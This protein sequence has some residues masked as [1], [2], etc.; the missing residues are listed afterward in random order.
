MVAAGIATAV[1]FE[2][3]EASQEED[4]PQLVVDAPRVGERAAELESFRI[5]Y[6]VVEFENEPRTEEHS[7]L[8]PYHGKVISERDGA[9]LT[10]S[11]SNE[12]GAFT[13]VTGTQQGWQLIDEGRKTSF[14]DMYADVALAW[15]LDK[16]MAEERGTETV[17]GRECTVFRTGAP[18]GAPVTAATDDEH[19]D[20]CVDEAGLILREDWHIDG[21]EVRRME[22]VEVDLDADLDP[23]DFEPDVRLP[24]LPTEA[25]GVTRVRKMTAVDRRELD[26]EVRSPEGYSF[27][28]A[29]VRERSADQGSFLSYVERFQDGHVLLDVEHGAH[30]PGYEPQGEVVDIGGGAKG[31][32]SIGYTSSAITILTIGSEY[33]R[34]VGPDLAALFEVA[35]QVAVGTG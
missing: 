8:R 15:A 7:V 11:L 9:F 30:G 14:G 13:Y 18:I 31:W 4:A 10:G 21:K 34:I 24:D 23:S 26:V 32:L 25:S 27:E 28:E 22:A 3:D 20:L 17:I 6:E 19:A 1:F 12:D 5:L 35:N 16:G 2:D 29:F 33:L